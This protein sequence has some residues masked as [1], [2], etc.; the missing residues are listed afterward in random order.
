ELSTFVDDVAAA[1]QGVLAAASWTDVGRALASALDRFLGGHRGVERWG[2]GTGVESDATYEQAAYEAVRA[3]VASL[4]SLDGGPPPSPDAVRRAVHDAFDRS[5]GN[6]TTLGRGVVVAPLRDLAG[7]DVDLLLVI[8]MTEEAMPPRLRENPLL[9][10]DERRVIGCGLMTVEDRRAQDRRDFDGAVAG[11]SEVVFSFPRADTRAQRRQHPSPWFMERLAQLTAG[12]SEPVFAKHVTGEPPAG[13]PLWGPASFVAALAADEAGLPAERSL[14]MAMAGHAEG[15]G[16]ARYRRARE[17]VAARRDGTF[18]PWTGHV[19]PLPSPLAEK[20]D[21]ALSAS[22]LQ[23][24]ATCPHT[25]WLEKVLEVRDLESVDDD[26]MDAAE[27]GSLVHAA[28]E[29]FFGEHV[30]TEQRPRLSPDRAWTAADVAR[31]RA[32]LDEEARKLEAQG[33]TGRPLLWRAERARLHRVLARVLAVDTQ[34]RARNRSWP[35]AVELPFGRH[36]V[37]P[38]TLQLPSSGEVRFAGSVDRVDMTESGGLVVMDYKTGKGYGYDAIPSVA[39]PDEAADLVDRGRKLQLVLYALAARRAF[40]PPARQ[41]ASY[42]W[43]V[44]LGDV[45]KGAPIGTAHEERLIEVLDVAVRGIREGVFPAHPGEWNGWSGWESCR[46]CPYD[47][48]CSTGRGEVWLQLSTADPVKA[49][50]SLISGAEET[51]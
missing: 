20:A 42:Y 3:A 10:D 17:A 41:V 22:S 13:V 35:V 43:F 39:K 25:F 6:R 18:G 23:R 8:G 50:A 29:R 11:A 38:L 4:E 5:A 15:V 7:A 24:W 44:E 36:D 51:A 37:E 19:G 27:R 14:A 30:P 45:H 31:A 46:F 34:L 16:G 47:R 9:R 2:R 21:A 26:V 32:L 28:L 33:R 1:A 40:A 48:V 12:R 49:Y